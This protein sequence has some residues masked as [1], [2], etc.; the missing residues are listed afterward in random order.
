MVKTKKKI[1]P[2]SYV[3]YNTLYKVDK[4]YNKNKKINTPIF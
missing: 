2:S 1:L 3:S 4:K